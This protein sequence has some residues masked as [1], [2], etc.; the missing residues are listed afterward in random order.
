MTLAPYFWSADGAPLGGW[1]ADGFRGWSAD[2]YEP[3]SLAVATTA[4]AAL[5]LNVGVL[6]YVFSSVVPIGYV[7]TGY[8]AFFGEPAGSYIPLAISNGPAPASRVR[9]VPNVVGKFYF[10]AQQM[11]LRSGL[12]IGYPVFALSTTVLPQYVISQSIAA[13]TQVAE[14]TMVSI[15][16]SGFSVLQQPGVPTPVP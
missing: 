13:G 11:I 2:G 10:D 4:L 6:T 7:I 9:F 5:G 16:V 8:P 3:T 12:L 15:I 1:S 14:Q